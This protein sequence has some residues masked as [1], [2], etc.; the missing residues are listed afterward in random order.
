MVGYYIITIKT[1]FD[2]NFIKIKLFNSIDKHKHISLA[3]VSIKKAS[4]CKLVI[5]KKVVENQNLDKKVVFIVL[6]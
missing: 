1:T 2:F 5:R 3:K 6:I 4:L